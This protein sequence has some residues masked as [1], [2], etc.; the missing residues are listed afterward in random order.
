MMRGFAARS[1]SRPRPILVMTPGRK[2]STTTSA[3]PTRSNTSARPSGL[4]SRAPTERLPQFSDAKYSDCPSTKCGPSDLASSGRSGSSILITSAPRSARI[5]V[6]Y[7]PARKWQKSSTRT[8]LSGPSTLPT[9]SRRRRASY[10]AIRPVAQLA[11]TSD[12]VLDRG[13]GGVDGYRS[14]LPKPVLV[15]HR[16]RSTDHDVDVVGSGCAQGVHHLTG[17]LDVRAAEDAQPDDVDVLLQRGGHDLLRPLPDA[18]V[19]DLAAGVAQGARDQL[20][21]AVVP[22]QAR[23]GD[24][25]ALPHQNHAGCW[26]SPQTPLSTSTISP[27]VQYAI[28]QS[29]SIGIRLVS[30]VL[31]LRSRLVSVRCTSAALRVRLTSA[32]RSSWRRRSSSCIS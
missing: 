11:D 8:P 29:T 13:A 23:L 9:S 17:E 2:L 18:G 5:M 7:G 16:N 4:L 24:Q 15:R 27:T 1:C 30:S 14:G 32:R 22:A 26:N 20:G 3:R 21:A 28:A 10:A 19:D 25:H 12:E 6:A 31:A